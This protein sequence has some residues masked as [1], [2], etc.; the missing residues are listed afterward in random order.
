MN[1]ALFD[2]DGTLTTKDSLGAFLRYSMSTKKY[3]LNMLRFLP[4]FALWKF[5]IMRND[6]AKQHLFKIFFNGMD[7]TAFKKMA[8]NFAHDKLS[9]IIHDERVELLKKHQAEGDRVIVVSASMKCWLEPWCKEMGVELLSTELEFKKNRFSGA[10]LT[11][12]CHGR[13]KVKRVK[14]LLNIDNYDTIYAYGDSSGDDEML[15]LAHHATKF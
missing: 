3:I 8:S 13:E 15:K 2:F 9:S 12:N 11:P 5:G 1:L 7:E 6:K 4:Y 14:E 10:F